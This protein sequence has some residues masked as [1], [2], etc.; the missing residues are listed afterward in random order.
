V[1][2]GVFPYWPKHKNFSWWIWAVQIG[3]Y[4]LFLF[5]V[6]VGLFVLFAPTSRDFQLDQKVKKIKKIRT[7]SPH[8]TTAPR[9]FLLPAPGCFP[10]ILIIRVVKNLLSVLDPESDFTFFDTTRF[11]EG[12]FKYRLVGTGQMLRH[13]FFCIRSAATNF[14]Y[15]SLIFCYLPSHHESLMRNPG[16][17][18]LNRNTHLI[19]NSQ[20]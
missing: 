10:V 14:E 16:L 18:W 7:A 12:P 17:S 1:G 20:S 9:I 4:T 11:G 8:A 2:W 5:S 15:K 13:L 19:T 6:A 3:S